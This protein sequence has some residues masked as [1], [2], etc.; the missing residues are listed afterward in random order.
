MLSTVRKCLAM[1]PPG[2]RWRWALLTPLGLL[3]GAVEAGAAAAVFGLI[4]IIGDPS[5][6][7]T[8]PVARTLVAWLPWRSPGAVILAFTL[9]VALYHVFKNALVVATAYIR[10]KFAGE[11]N[12]AL[13][14]AL[15]K[16]YLA[17]PYPL[18]FRRNSAELIRNV[19]EAVRTVFKALDAAMAALTEMLVA[20]G[21]AS[22]MI[23]T[24]PR[25]TLAAGG[26]LVVLL[27]LLLRGTRSMAARYGHG[28]HD[29]NR[30]MLQSLQQALG[31]IKEIKALGRERYF[32]E[33]Y[34]R[35][36]QDM[37]DV[38]YVETTLE[39]LPPLVIETAFVC[40]A[41]A[42]VAI[43]TA[44]GPAGTDGL[45]VIALFAYA[46]F[47]IVPSANRVT[48]RL[49]ELRA[50][51]EAV[52]ALYEDHSLIGESDWPVDG[53][54]SAPHFERSIDLDGV[55]FAYPGADEPVLHDISLHIAHGES[56]GVVGPTGAGK[57]TLVDLIAGLLEPTS[58]TVKVDGA[59]LTERLT[60]WKRRIGYVPQSI[61]LTDDTL[62]RNIALGIGDEDIDEAHLAAALRL[63]QLEDFVRVLP[64]GL[65]TTVGERGVRLSGGE[66]QRVGIA[67][68]LYH[69]P[70]VLLFDE[71]T[72]ALDGTT[73]REVARAIEGLLGEKTMVIVAHRPSTVRRCHR[74]LFL[75]DGRVED[76]GP[77]E[78][79]AARNADLQRMLSPAPAST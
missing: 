20:A 33:V 11:A 53:N 59:P 14:C 23:V 5:K 28:M 16:S 79:L 2:H 56:I 17:A 44:G 1:L 43:V 67:R 13:S 61:Y 64:A 6:A 72:S 7:S 60:A 27:F 62:R 4:N 75:R 46:G 18:H 51:R 26:V 35:R 66:R 25:V 42:V 48:W 55:S 9:M 47:R 63:A 38:G 73:E 30:R 74:L 10:H 22:V 31:G 15:L 32:Y 45:P 50:A 19:N 70:D 78:E 52:N 37:L 77:F 8:L 69:D 3:A 76:S 24:A 68:A 39:V 29:L 65:D 54:G 71:A 58:G 40:G 21:I 34:A 57:S 41:L 49:N 12:A 36:R